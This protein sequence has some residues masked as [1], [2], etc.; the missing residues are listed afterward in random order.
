MVKFGLFGLTSFDF[1]IPI[2][3]GHGRSLPAFIIHCAYVT[4]EQLHI[5]VQR[6]RDSQLTYGDGDVLFTHCRERL[7]ALGTPVPQKN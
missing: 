6:G 5:G 7:G 4:N 1:G 2:D 3:G